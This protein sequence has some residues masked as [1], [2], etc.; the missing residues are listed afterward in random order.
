MAAELKLPEAL[1]EEPEQALFFCLGLRFPFE[2]LGL[3]V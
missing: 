1:S 2:G 3:R